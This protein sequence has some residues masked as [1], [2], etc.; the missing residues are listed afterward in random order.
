MQKAGWPLYTNSCRSSFDA[1][2]QNE[3]LHY[4][5]FSHLSNLRPIKSTEFLCTCS[6]PTASSRQ[7]FL[8][9]LSFSKKVDYKCLRELKSRHLAVLTRLRTRLDSK[10]I[11]KRLRLHDQK[12]RGS[13]LNPCSLMLT[14]RSRKA[15]HTA[16][17]STI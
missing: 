2:S 17:Y 14:Q 10:K 1:T 11:V 4:S 8:F 6:L 3:A 5:I 16:R 15:A 13:S 9:L 7:I 12:K